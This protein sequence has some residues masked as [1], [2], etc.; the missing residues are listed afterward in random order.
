[1]LHAP[2]GTEHL[3]IL[4]VRYEPIPVKAFSQPPGAEA[5]PKAPPRTAG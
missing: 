2:A 5:A 4:D 1:V 3:Q